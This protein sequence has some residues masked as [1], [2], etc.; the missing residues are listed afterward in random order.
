MISCAYNLNYIISI[1]D[2]RKDREYKEFSVNY[3]G[4]SNNCASNRQVDI[5]FDM[6]KAQWGER[7]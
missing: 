3:L 7:L 2:W 6:E 5:F 1:N 4:H